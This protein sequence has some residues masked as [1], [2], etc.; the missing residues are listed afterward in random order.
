MVEVFLAALASLVSVSAA[1]AGEIHRLVDDGQVG[2]VKELLAKDPRL[3]GA[4]DRLQ[5]TPLHIA[6]R[7]GHLDMVKLLLNRGAKVNARAHNGDTPLHLARDPRIVKLL[8]AHK[9]DLEAKG[10]GGTALERA[11][12]YCTD[13]DGEGDNT[14][15]SIVRLLLDAGAYYDMRSAVYLN[16]LKRVRTL[17]NKDPKGTRRQGLLATAAQAGHCALVKLLQD[18]NADP[19]EGEGGGLPALYYAIEHPA[20]VRL[21]LSAGARAMVRLEDR[22]PSTGPGI[23]SGWTLLHAAAQYGPPGS[24]KALLDRGA[25]VDARDEYGRTPLHEAAYGGRPHVVR[26]LLDRC[27][28]PK[29]RTKD[30]WTTMTLAAA[31]VGDEGE[32][33][34]DP[35]RFRRVIAGLAEYGVPIDLFTA[36]TLNRPH[37]VKELLK[38]Q[39]ALANSKHPGGNPILCEAVRW[40]RAEIVSLL[41]AGG[42]K[43]NAT[44][45]ED[46]ITVPNS[47]SECREG[48]TPLHLAA[49]NG[50]SGIARILLAAGAR[51]NAKDK[52]GQTP[53]ARA[54]AAAGTEKDSAGRV[55]RRFRELIRLLRKHGGKK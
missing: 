42:A 35:A 52:E 33:G 20:I 15:R 18:H 38:V 14:W 23:P 36:I 3:L 10:A 40:D 7:N 4:V 46:S 16:D 25:V 12:S 22:G 44:E 31:R 48:T 27:A 49:E 47:L 2:K 51:V 26:V 39:P 32:K 53:L 24:V 9:A 41:L 6:A 28:D 45:K 29:A 11:A 54:L 8:I 55:P 5:R 13:A 17:L 21:L 1:Q 30:G 43:V 50:S 19:N 37:R 34:D